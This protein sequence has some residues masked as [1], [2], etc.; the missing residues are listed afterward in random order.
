[1]ATSNSGLVV[2][3]LLCISMAPEVLGTTAEEVP[4]K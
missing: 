4:R 2:S 1:M 3:M